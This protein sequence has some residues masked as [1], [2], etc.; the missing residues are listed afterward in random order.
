MSLFKGFTPLVYRDVPGWGVYF[1]S[2]D[3]LKDMFGLTRGREQDSFLN[4]MIMVWCG[5]VAGQLSWV[6]AYPFDIIKT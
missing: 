4:L 6:C 2:Y 1:Y 3:L 5:G